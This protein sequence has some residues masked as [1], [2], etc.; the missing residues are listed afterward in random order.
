MTLLT[1]ILANTT[2]EGFFERGYERFQEH[3][4]DAKVEKCC[5]ILSNEQYRLKEA[6]DIYLNDV[7]GVTIEFLETVFTKLIEMGRIKPGFSP[8]LLA[9]EYQYAMFSMLVEYNL[10]RFDHKDTTEIET[11]MKNHTNFFLEVVKKS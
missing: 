2:L 9:S 5:R 10:L 3:L 8:A 1:D 4:S 6:R 11:K 7:I